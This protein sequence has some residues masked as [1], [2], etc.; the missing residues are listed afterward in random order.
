MLNF[1]EQLKVLVEAAFKEDIG[2]GD[3]STLS[4]ISPDAKGKAVL[5]IKQDG[6]LAGIEVAEKIFKMKEAN[7]KF[8]SFK[9]DGDPMKAGEHAFEVE[10]LVHTILLCER[11]VLNC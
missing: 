9:K 7:A 10:A 2:D 3:H 6:I 4:C 11:L 8:T 5:K 1:D